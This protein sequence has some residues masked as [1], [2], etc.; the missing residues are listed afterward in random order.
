[1][2]DLREA[3]ECLDEFSTSIRAGCATPSNKVPKGYLAEKI[4]GRNDKQ[5]AQIQ[6]L[7]QESVKLS[8]HL[9]DAIVDDPGNFDD[10]S[11]DFRAVLTA[12][13]ENELARMHA[14]EA[15]GQF[16]KATADEA[17][18]GPKRNATAEAIRRFEFNEHLMTPEERQA[19]IQE[20]GEGTST[21]GASPKP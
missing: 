17:N 7:Q 1:M 3:K 2:M 10:F 18:K 6:E 12:L 19:F 5:I 14:A 9:H 8:I 20:F 15:V 13:R 16:V 21:H 4:I 11:I